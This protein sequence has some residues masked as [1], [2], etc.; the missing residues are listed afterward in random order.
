MDAAEIKLTGT[1]ADESADYHKRISYP[2][3]LH[4]PFR[5]RPKYCKDQLHSIIPESVLVDSDLV[6]I[7]PF[8]FN[9]N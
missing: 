7:Q 5:L 6:I 8:V 1:P 2:G 4:P 9:N 3:I